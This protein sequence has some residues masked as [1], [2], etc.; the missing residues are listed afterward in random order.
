V[1]GMNSTSYFDPTGLSNRNQS[2]AHDLAL[3][4]A[5]AARNPVIR[6]FSTTPTHLASLNGRTLQYRNSNRL[7]RSETSGWDIE[8]QKTGYIVESGRCLTMLA[9]VG[10]HNLIMVLLD[11]GS[12]A[13]RLS[14]AQHLRK[15]VVAQNGW[16]DAP[17]VAKAPTPAPRETVAAKEPPAKAEKVA[18]AKTTHKAGKA[19]TR[20]TAKA[21]KARTEVAASK[22]ATSANKKT[23]VAKKGGRVSKTYAARA[24]HKG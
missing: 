8:L 18:A 7:V 9:K 13:T 14:D 11:S 1:L 23:A 10:G 22:K 21:A 4:V 3:L 2:T 24:D 12:N 15:W 5:E 6:D 16:E 19:S 17:V 20:K